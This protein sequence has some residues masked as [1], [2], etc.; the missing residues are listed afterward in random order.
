MLLLYSYIR[1]IVTQITFLYEI[2]GV[3]IVRVLYKINILREEERF[4]IH[5][6]FLV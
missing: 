3:I 1:L 4:L 6:E 2:Y 5:E